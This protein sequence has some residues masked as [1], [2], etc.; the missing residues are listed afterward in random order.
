[1][2]FGRLILLIVRL[3]TDSIK[4]AI[5]WNTVTAHLKVLYIVISSSPVGYVRR[6]WCTGSLQDRHTAA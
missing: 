6:C 2:A 3:K 5:H 4:C 1:M